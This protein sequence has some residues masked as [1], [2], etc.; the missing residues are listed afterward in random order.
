MKLSGNI[1]LSAA[2]AAAMVCFA[3]LLPWTAAAQKQTDQYPKV[4]L[5]SQD[6]AN[7]GILLLQID[8]GMELP[9][10]DMHIEFSR[11]SYRIYRHP[12]GTDSLYFTL[13]GI[14]YRTTPGLQKL[15]LHY[16]DATG[17][18][19]RLIPFQV[20]AGKYKTDILKVD[21]RRVNPNKEDRRRASR[22]H[23]E[24]KH[25]YASGI[26][27]RLW[28]GKF[29]LPVDNEISSRFGNRRVFNGGFSL[30]ER[31][32]GLCGQFGCREAGKKFVL[33]RQCRHY[34]PRHGDFHDLCPP[35]QNQNGPQPAH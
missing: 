31:Y 23:Q 10:T 21:G 14:P 25:V 30:T 6:V 9:P 20:V 2:A 35:E 29:Q 16:S 3:I 34:R 18:E 27:E 33:F 12:A 11:H 1:G 22:E 13:I 17:A 5:S 4:F 32:P 8:T 24:V 15:N 28:E 7:G 19:S 26:K